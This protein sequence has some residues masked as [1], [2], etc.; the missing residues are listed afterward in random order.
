MA[1]SCRAQRFPLPFAVVCFF[2]YVTGVVLSVRAVCVAREHAG[3][4][5][6]LDPVVS[7]LLLLSCQPLFIPFYMMS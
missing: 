7:S 4:G 2:S 5:G 1:A 6:N 3:E